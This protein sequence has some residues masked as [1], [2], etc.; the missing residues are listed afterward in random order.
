MAA[1]IGLES[2]KILDR[3]IGLAV[4]KTTLIMLAG[5]VALSSFFSLIDELSRAGQANYSILQAVEYTMLNVPQQAYDLLPLVAVV[6]GMVALSILARNGELTIVRG[7][8]VSSAR[9]LLSVLRAGLLLAVL[10]IVLGEFIAPPAAQYA[11]HLRSVAL[12]QQ[13]FLKARHGYWTRDGQSFINIRR[14]LPGD[15]LEQIYI[16]EFDD[17]KR[18]R[19][20]TFAKRAHYS[21]GQ[22]FLEDLEQIFIDDDGVSKSKIARAKWESA[23]RPDM[24]NSVIVKPKHLSAWQLFDY[25]GYLKSNGQESVLYEQALWGKLTHPF[26]IGA[27]VLIAVPIVLASLQGFGMAQRV[28]MAALV[29]VAFHV[30]TEMSAHLGIVYNINPGISMAVPTLI[31]IAITLVLMRRA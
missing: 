3:Y 7:A 24:I 18:L 21:D 25:I 5:L 20:S 27:M 31:I 22:W 28:L 26:A 29:G 4:V 10:A 30:S 19:T 1:G 15:R 9:V 8:G 17:A 13:L 23:L 16:Y 14:I 6:G 11:R 2:M 12:T